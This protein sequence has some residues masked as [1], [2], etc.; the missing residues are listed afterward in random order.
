MDM[1]PVSVFL[2]SP[3]PS[4]TGREGSQQKK[5]KWRDLMLSRVVIGLLIVTI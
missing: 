4:H 5:G 3:D 2:F 1:P